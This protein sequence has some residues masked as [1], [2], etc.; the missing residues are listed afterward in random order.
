MAEDTAPGEIRRSDEVVAGLL[1]RILDGRLRPGDRLPAERDLAT[2]YGVSRTALREAMSNLTGRG[3]IASRGG[4]GLRI[5]AV[6]PERAQEALFLYLRDND[7]DYR[8]IHEVREVIEVHAAGAAAER[9]DAETALLLSAANEELRASGED[10]ARAVAADF[11]FHR[12]VSVMAG[13]EIFSLLLS[14]LRGGLIRVR[15]H[16]L[17]LRA[18]H[19]EAC[20]SHQAIVDAITAHDPDAARA[21]MASHLSAVFGYWHG[22]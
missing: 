22:D 14:S 1:R 12:L 17:T 9:G 15:E 2:E 18:A 6:A 21:A 16:N 5:T 10:V 20:D 19:Q 11:E 7:L 3:L 13:N 8:S 4:S